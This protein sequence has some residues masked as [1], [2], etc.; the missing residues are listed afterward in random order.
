MKKELKSGTLSAHKAADRRPTVGG[1]NV[2]AVLR[3]LE[4]EREKENE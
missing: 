1:I 2:I 3:F 4:S